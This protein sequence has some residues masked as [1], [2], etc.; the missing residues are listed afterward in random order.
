MTRK[1][2]LVVD[3]NPVIVKTTSMKLTANGY[4]VVTAQDGAGAVSAVRKEMPDLILLDISFPPDVGS[5]GVA[6]DGFAIMSWLRRLEDSKNIPIIVVSGSAP[7]K[8]KDRALAA[9]AVSYFHKPINNDELL[10]AIRDTLAKSTE[11]T[12]PAI[13]PAPQSPSH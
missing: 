6:W 9:G 1:K 11:N 10:A 5:G 13:P 12:L 2:I 8:F 4:D 7:A 3:D